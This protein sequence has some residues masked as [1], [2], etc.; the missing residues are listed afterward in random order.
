M[1]ICIVSDSHDNRPLLRA[2][3]E[4]AAQ[5]GAE[6]IIHCGDVG[7]QPVFDE[8]VGRPFYFVWGNMDVPD[9]PTREYLAAVGLNEPDG[10]PMLLEWGGK[11]I[12]VFHGYENGFR[13]AADTL[14]VDYILF[15]HTHRP[16]DHRVGQVRL[17]TPGAIHRANVP[18]VATLDLT[19]DTLTYYELT[20]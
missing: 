15:G 2:A 20:S 7:G 3:V 18:T 8:F 13:T 17:I 16:Y 9:A 11:R 6:A 19:T 1:K 14:D 12:A 4:Q 10:V 5:W